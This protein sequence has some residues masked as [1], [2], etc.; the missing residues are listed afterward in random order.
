MLINF[1]LNIPGRNNQLKMEG[2]EKL[3]M[4]FKIFVGK[5]QLGF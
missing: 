4:N 3:R 1:M 2:Q 5:L